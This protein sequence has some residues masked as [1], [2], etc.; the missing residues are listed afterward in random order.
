MEIAVKAELLVESLV[1]FIESQKKE[2]QM[3]KEQLQTTNLNTDTYQ[4]VD[5]VLPQ[6][7]HVKAPWGKPLEEEKRAEMAQR[8]HERMI[9]RRTRYWKV[10]NSIES[11]TG[12]N[13]KEFCQEYF[14]GKCSWS[15][16]SRRI[17]HAAGSWS[18][19]HLYDEIIKELEQ[20]TGVKICG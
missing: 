19:P 5:S 11:A 16:L 14:Q 20:E 10:I 8:N 4:P 15:G 9:L 18:F 1:A 13:F 12:L 6:P 17:Y 2:I 7:L 3:L